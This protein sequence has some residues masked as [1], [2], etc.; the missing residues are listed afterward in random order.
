MKISLYDSVLLIS[1]NSL[2]LSGLKTLTNISIKGLDL[3]LSKFLFSVDGR[4]TWKTYDFTTSSWIDVSLDDIATSGL[5]LNQ[6]QKLTQNEWNMLASDANSLDIAIYLKSVPL[7]TVYLDNKLYQMTIKV[8][9]NSTESK[10]GYVCIPIKVDPQNYSLYKEDGSDVTWN[11]SD[12]L[13]IQDSFNAN[14]TKVYKLIY[15]DCI[16]NRSDSIHLGANLCTSDPLNTGDVLAYLTTDGSKVL[17]NMSGV[18]GAYPYDTGD[19]DLGC[20]GYI[21]ETNHA[22]WNYTLSSTLYDWTIFAIIGTP[23]LEYR[24]IFTNTNS[25]YKGTFKMAKDGT[26]SG[27][28]SIYFYEQSTGGFGYSFPKDSFPVV[29]CIRSDSSTNK[30][31]YFANG[32]LVKTQDGVGKFQAGTYSNKTIEQPYSGGLIFYFFNRALSDDEIMSLFG[33]VKCESDMITEYCNISSSTNQI[34]L[35]PYY[36][37]STYVETITKLP[38]INADYLTYKFPN[39]KTVFTKDFKTFYVYDSTSNSFKQLS[40]TTGETLEQHVSEIT[41]VDSLSSKVLYE[42]FGNNVY[43]LFIIETSSS[44]ISYDKINFDPKK[45]PVLDE[46]SVEGLLQGE[47]H[48]VSIDGAKFDVYE[49]GPQKIVITNKSGNDETLRL[50]IMY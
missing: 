27:Y 35:D 44:Q 14:E 4:T 18:S 9:N 34:I 47:W 33:G 23:Y 15:T 16:S 12:K 5:S 46:V 29:V 40:L 26:Q 1:A 2:N 11:V 36:T 39:K 10:S 24:H 42:T 20:K 8:T 22:T 28:V 31:S 3:D 21:V 38:I 45:P 30:L 19:K 25:Q 48:W 50:N 7:D 13:I 49:Q 37:S 17:T 32:K 6:I 41:V 43:V